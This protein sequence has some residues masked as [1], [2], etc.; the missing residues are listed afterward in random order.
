MHDRTSVFD[1]FGAKNMAEFVNQSEDIEFGL[2]VG[3]LVMKDFRDRHDDIAAQTLS[4]IT[5]T[6]DARPPRCQ[7]ATDAL[8]SKGD[9]QVIVAARLSREFFFET[10]E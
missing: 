4:A 3:A 2:A 9:E 8:G 10:S 5:D 7:N 6:I 1:M